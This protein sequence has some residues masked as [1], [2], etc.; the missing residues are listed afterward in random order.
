[1]IILEGPDG[2]GKTS[3]MSTLLDRFPRIEEHERASTSKGGPVQNIF[4]WAKD[5]ILSWGTQPLSFYDRH[6]LISEPIYGEHIRGKFDGRFTDALGEDLGM[7][8]FLTGLIIVC[9]PPK[10]EV[11]INVNLS[12]VDQMSGVAENIIPIYDE[13]QDLLNQSRGRQNVFWYDYTRPGDLSQLLYVVEAYYI[14]WN[15][16]R[17]NHG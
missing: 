9:L 15:K 6:P 2:S 7:H 10:S 4:E 13:Y 5:D 11:V 8:M 14:M 1:M 3:L 16:I 12:V 17:G